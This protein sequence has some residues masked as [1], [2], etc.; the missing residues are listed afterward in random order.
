MAPRRRDIVIVGAGPTGLALACELFRRD[1]PCRV[2]E[3]ATARSEVDYLL[4][5]LA[6]HD[7]R[8]RFD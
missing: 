6:R 4:A 5:R 3:S 7:P 2:V 1:V 8:A